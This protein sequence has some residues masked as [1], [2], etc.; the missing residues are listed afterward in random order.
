MMENKETAG[1]VELAV[2][3]IG[4]QKRTADLLGVTPQAVT[5]WIKNDTVPLSRITE[6]CRI[7]QVHPRAVN[8]DVARLFRD[9]R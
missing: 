5:K 9:W 8:P 3:K 2:R 1:G 6:F 4:G 7:A